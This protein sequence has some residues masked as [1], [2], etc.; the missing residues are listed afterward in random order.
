VRGI[1]T[2]RNVD[3]VGLVVPDLTEAVEFFTRVLGC[4][5]LYHTRESFDSTGGDWMRRHY[6]VPARA[7]LRTAMLRCGPATNLELLQWDGV[8]VPRGADGLTRA[9]TG[10]LAIYVDDLET[11]TAYLAAHPGVRVLGG[12]V[13]AAGEPN[14][15]T[16]C[17]RVLLPWGMSLEVVQWPPLMPYCL[18]TAVR[19]YGLRSGSGG[20]G[21]DAD[22]AGRRAE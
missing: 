7:R 2:A 3:H 8:D 21:P 20:P 13:V 6:G 14:E 9:G 10:H 15:G 4:D 11:A 16:A 1:P 12:P 19:L 18:T 5:L 17:A 22:D